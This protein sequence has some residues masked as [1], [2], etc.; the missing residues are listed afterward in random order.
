MR[1]Y[2]EVHMSSY[3]VKLVFVRRP[4]GTASIVELG[5]CLLLLLVRSQ[6]WLRKP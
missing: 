2:A 6:C 5:S 1:T 3:S 4:I